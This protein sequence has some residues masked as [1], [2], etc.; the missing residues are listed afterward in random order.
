VLPWSPIVECNVFYIRKCKIRQPKEVSFSYCLATSVASVCLANDLV[1]IVDVDN[2][3]CTS[4][5]WEQ[6]K[7]VIRE[8]KRRL[9]YTHRNQLKHNCN[10]IY[11][12]QITLALKLRRLHF[13]Q[14]MYLMFPALICTD[15]YYVTKQHWSVFFGME[16]Q[17][18]FSVLWTK[19]MNIVRRVRK[20]A[21]GDYWF[22]VRLSV[23]NNSALTGRI[24][25]K[26]GIWVLFKTLSRKGFY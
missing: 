1:P 26:F 15:C 4:I 19:T 25:M 18:V 11:H 22:H 17:G 20:I 8:F 21:N 7:A 5:I 3:C 12:T 6:T 24:F 14:I 2:S 13:V 23:R 9:S 10:Y 16:N